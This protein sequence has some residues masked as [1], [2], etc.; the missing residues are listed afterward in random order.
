MTHLLFTSPHLT[1]L[2]FSLSPAFPPLSPPRFSESP[3]LDH[4]FISSPCFLSSLPPQ[5]VYSIL[6][7]CCCCWGYRAPDPPSEHG[8]LFQ[9]L[10]KRNAGHRGN[11]SWHRHELVLQLLS[12]MHACMDA[13]DRVCVDAVL[14]VYAWIEWLC[15]L[16]AHEVYELMMPVCVPLL[17][18]WLVSLLCALMVHMCS[19][20]KRTW[21]LPPFPAYIYFE[22]S[23]LSSCNVIRCNVLQCDVMFCNMLWSYRMLEHMEDPDFNSPVPAPAPPTDSASSS[24][25]SSAAAHTGIYMIQ[26]SWMTSMHYPFFPPLP[27]PSLL[28]LPFIHLPFV[29]ISW[30]VITLLFLSRPI[31]YNAPFPSFPPLFFHSFIC[32]FL[33][34]KLLSKFISLFMMRFN[35][36]FTAYCYNESRS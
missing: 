12:S 27:L 13:I 16:S 23:F 35:V 24:E 20:P 29:F 8:V 11:W 15:M 10:S 26:S 2:L 22:T 14:S 30:F 3:L 1:S 31:V 34:Y 32:V 36:Y 4:S 9:W 33:S 21:M 28:F 6:C 18:G 7:C 5:S 19:L 17:R 25:S